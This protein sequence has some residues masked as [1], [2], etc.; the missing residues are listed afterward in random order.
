[1]RV[2]SNH[3][4]KI[5]KAMKTSELV[6]RAVQL[7]IMI[8][9]VVESRLAYGQVAEEDLVRKLVI[10]R[11]EVG[12]PHYTKEQ[13][14]HSLNLLR[15]VLN[16][17]TD[18]AGRTVWMPVAKALG[19]SLYRIAPPP[20]EIDRSEVYTIAIDSIGSI[21]IIRDAEEFTNQTLERV[22]NVD[23]VTFAGLID[24]YDAIEFSDSKTITRTEYDPSLFGSRLNYSNYN[25][26]EEDQTGR[27]SCFKVVQTISS[28]ETETWRLAYSLSCRAFKVHKSLISKVPH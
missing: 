26:I 3:Q 24:L 27:F 10:I 22:R 17:S 2:G 13:L 14:T 19:V 18:Y 28:Q 8:F 7:V 21:D 5:K 6:R 12:A 4:M 20:I 25:R 9:A 15:R 1:M 11:E 23:R 16:D